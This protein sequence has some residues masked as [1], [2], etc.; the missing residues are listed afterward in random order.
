MLA[1]YF[2][3]SIYDLF[4]ESLHIGFLPPK[5]QSGEQFLVAHGEV[6][7]CECVSRQLQEFLMGFSWSAVKELGDVT[8]LAPSLLE[9]LQNKPTF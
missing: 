8:P 1:L 6:D 7:D 2:E 9:E 5:L 4:E 3:P